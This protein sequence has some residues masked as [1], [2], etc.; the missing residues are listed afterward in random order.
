MIERGHTQIGGR[1]VDMAR[2]AAG[3]MEV[4]LL[5]YGAI[6][7]D[8]RIG[9]RSVVLGHDD[10]ADYGA[11]PF[12]LGVIAGRVANRIAGGRFLIGD[13][14]VVLPLNDGGNHLHGG[15]R[16]LSQRH[17][18]IEA[19]TGENAVRLSCVSGHGDGGYPGRAA[20]E[21]VVTLTDTRLSYEMR[22][23]VDRPTPINLAQHNYY[24]LTGGEI[25]DHE[26]RVAAAEYL[27]VDDGGIPVGGRAPVAGTTMDFRQPRRLGEADGD[28]EGTDHCLVLSGDQPA[29][30]LTAPGGPELRFHTDQPGLQLYTGKHLEGVHQPFTGVCLEP[31]GFPDAVNHPGFPSVMVYPDAPY[32]QRL[33]IEVA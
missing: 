30:I 27:P 20:F 26:L 19:N 21:V 13:D 33:S 6:T 24:N 12:F 22:A 31:E 14:E 3:N 32:T 25:W 9:G 23:K 11:D 17:W 4:M 5:S 8:W 10:P 16:G 29:A 2:L 1:A 7:R 15:P 18:D 28:H